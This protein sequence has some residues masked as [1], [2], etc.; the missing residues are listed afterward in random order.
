[1]RFNIDKNDV[2]CIVK[3]FV[4]YKEKVEI[5]ID[6]MEVIAGYDNAEA[7]FTAIPRSYNSGEEAKDKFCGYGETEFRA[8]N[9]CLGKIKDVKYEDIFE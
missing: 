6:V 9:N 7:K 5:P 1:M 4:L 2:L 8:L 3:K